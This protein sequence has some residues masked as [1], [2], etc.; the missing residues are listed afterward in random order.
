MAECAAAPQTLL[1]YSVHQYAGEQSRAVLELLLHI[2][3]EHQAVMY[4]HCWALM[5]NVLCNILLR[6][7]RQVFIVKKP[8]T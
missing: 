6:C 4:W 3:P 2:A 8:R 7:C 5:A 1:R